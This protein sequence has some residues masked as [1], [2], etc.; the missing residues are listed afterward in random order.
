MELHIPPPC[1]CGRQ[2][3]GRPGPTQDTGVLTLTLTPHPAVSRGRGVWE[4]GQSC[5]LRR[6]GQ[7]P[8]PL[9][10]HSQ[11]SCILC[12]APSCSSP[13]FTWKLLP[14]V[15]D[16]S[17]PKGT[18]PVPCS[19]SCPKF[20]GI[21]GKGENWRH[22]SRLQRMRRGSSRSTAGT[23][24]GTAGTEELN[25]QFG[26]FLEGFNEPTGSGRA[27][28]LLNQCLQSPGP[29]Q[30]SLSVPGQSLLEEIRQTPLGVEGVIT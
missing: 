2:Q 3:Q 9:Q 13:E 21:P 11:H 5:P 26:D 27:L 16:I 6:A 20:P 12:P 17:P 24:W 23:C 18:A 14:Q 28:L 22:T 30:L 1:Q 15:P 7:F 4:A 25:A 8:A 10:P 29:T 19:L